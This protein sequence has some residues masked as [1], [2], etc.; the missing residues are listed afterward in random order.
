MNTCELFSEKLANWTQN[1]VVIVSCYNKAVN[2]KNTKMGQRGNSHWQKTAWEE[3]SLRKEARLPY[4]PSA[5]SAWGQR[6]KFCPQGLFSYHLIQPGDPQVKRSLRLEKEA[7]KCCPHTAG[8]CDIPEN[9]WTAWGLEHKVVGA[10]LTYKT[11][12]VS[13]Y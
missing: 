3:I 8:V 7:V 13:A 11:G 9:L 10:R 1:C 4:T 2:T 12:F 6:G 5:T